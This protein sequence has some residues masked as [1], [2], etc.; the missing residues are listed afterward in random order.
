MAGYKPQS[1]P[2][3][4]PNHR[5]PK[6]PFSPLPDSLVQ[7]APMMLLCMACGTPRCATPEGV[8]LWHPDALDPAHECAGGGAPGLDLESAA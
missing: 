4:K 8:V 7:A 6:E 3:I 1:E 5:R 2:V